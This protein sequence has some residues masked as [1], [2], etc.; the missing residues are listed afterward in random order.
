MLTD[1]L[2]HEERT[3]SFIATLLAR[4]EKKNEKF[5]QTHRYTY[6]IIFSKHEIKL[7]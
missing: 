2:Q 3:N 6:C 4:N 7:T 5:F 1:F